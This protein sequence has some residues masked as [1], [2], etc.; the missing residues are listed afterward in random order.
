MVID[1]PAIEGRAGWVNSVEVGTFACESTEVGCIGSSLAVC[2]ARCEACGK[3]RV[4]AAA[5]CNP[6]SHGTQPPGDLMGAHPGLRRPQPRLAVS[7]PAHPVF[8]GAEFCACA[9]HTFSLTPASARHWVETAP[10]SGARGL[11]GR[12]A[13]P[14]SVDRPFLNIVIGSRGDIG[15]FRIPNALLFGGFWSTC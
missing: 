13:H 7:P 15:P 5:P 12:W 8:S 2:G 3:P 6:I 1:T 10:G 9:H 14:T 11:A 4:K